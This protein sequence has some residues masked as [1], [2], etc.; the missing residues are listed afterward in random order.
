MTSISSV[1]VVPRASNVTVAT[2]ASRAESTKARQ[3]EVGEGPRTWSAPMRRR[4]QRLMTTA[5][6]VLST[7]GNS[8]LSAKNSSTAFRAP[9]H[10]AKP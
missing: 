1:D 4:R 5:C 7:K 6:P 2:P 3:K 8:A 9:G 10:D